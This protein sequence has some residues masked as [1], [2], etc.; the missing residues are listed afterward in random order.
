[1]TLVILIMTVSCSILDAKNDQAEHKKT[2][3]MKFIQAFSIN[4]NITS[5]LNTERSTKDIKCLH[6]LRVISIFGIVFFHTVWT[7][8]FNP[9][10]D[11]T[12]FEEFRDSNTASVI[13]SFNIYVD[14]FFVMTAAIM[15]RLVLSQLER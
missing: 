4:S 7:R 5:L 9:N 11:Q 15:T 6:G 1:M 14:T 10:L 3:R 2:L 8:I 12:K 13:N